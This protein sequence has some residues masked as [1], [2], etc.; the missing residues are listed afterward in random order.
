MVLINTA[1]RFVIALMANPQSSRIDSGFNK[2]RQSM[3]KQSHPHLPVLENAISVL[4]SV[5]SVLPAA[6]GVGLVDGCL[7]L[8]DN[9]KRQ[10]GD[11]F[12]LNSSHVVSS[13]DDAIRAV[14]GVSAPSRLDLFYQ[15][16]SPL[17]TF[18]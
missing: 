16:E 10:F 17:T 7:E 3:R 6:V 11:W 2:I 15:V 5:S 18:K 4:I 1:A 12:I 9:L 13:L 14:L 8:L